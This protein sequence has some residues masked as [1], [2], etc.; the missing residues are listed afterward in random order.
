MIIGACTL[1]LRLHGVG[2]LKDKRSI[3]KPI[4]ARLR[5]EFNV[6]VAEVDMHD[7]WETAVLGLAVVSNDAGHAHAQIEKCIDW[8]ERQRLDADL[9]TYEIE[10]L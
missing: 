4:T 8:I 3:V 6:S 2:S 10:M 5:Q 9:V 7:A 1:E